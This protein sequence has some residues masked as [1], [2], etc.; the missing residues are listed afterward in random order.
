MSR[1]VIYSLVSYK[2]ALYAVSS[3]V[4]APQN[5]IKN[6]L[7]KLMKRILK[8]LLHNQ[9]TDQTLSFK[10]FLITPVNTFSFWFKIV[11]YFFRESE[12]I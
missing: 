9:G 8:I 7:F 1:A 10:Q 5:N 6:T 3:K 4:S 11:Y 2:L 12:P